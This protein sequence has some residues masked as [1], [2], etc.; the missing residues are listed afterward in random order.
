MEITLFIKAKRSISMKK[1]Y[2]TFQVVLGICAAL[3][4][5]GVFYP[6]LTL[7]PDT[8]KVMGEDGREALYGADLYYNILGAGKNR[9][10][11]KSKLITAV[12]AI[13]HETGKRE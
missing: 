4:W 6:E 5:W 8:Y 1:K 7:T 9:I 13:V 10:Y 12:E 3:G 11:F 2:A